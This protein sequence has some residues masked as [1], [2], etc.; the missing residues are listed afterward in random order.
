MVLPDG[1]RGNVVE[2]RVHGVS[3]TPPEELLDRQLVR[4][5]AGDA[6]AGFYRPRLREEWRDRPGNEPETD[7]EPYSTGSEQFP[8]PLLEGYSWGGLTSGSPSRALWLVLLPFTLINVAPRMR[9]V[10]GDT[11]D[12]SR[13][14]AWWVW[15]LARVMA[16]SL[17]ATIALGAT[18][19]GLTILAWQCSD[20]CENLPWPLSSMFVD[21]S[22]GW[23]VIWGAAIPFTLL[24]LL[25]LLS[26]RKSVQYDLIR[27]IGMSVPV[28]D[29]AETGTTAEPRLADPSFW[30]GRYPVSRLRHL[31]LQAG[32]AVVGFALVISS[33]S[34]G[35]RTAGILLAG[36]IGALVLVGLGGDGLLRRS[37]IPGSDTVEPSMMARFRNT[38]WIL[39]IWVPV[40]VLV[41]VGFALP[42]AADGTMAGYDP[43]V[44]AWFAGQSVLTLVMLVLIAVMASR[45]KARVPRRAAAGLGTVVLTILALYLGAA[46]TSGFVI[47]SAAWITSSTP[48]IGI[49]DV[50]DLL[51]PDSPIMVPGAL[52][53]AGIG[54]FAVAAVVLVVIVVTVVY[55]AWMWARG[56]TR[57][58]RRHADEAA[59]AAKSGD[60]AQFG[61]HRPG[62]I[63]RRKKSIS[64]SIWLARRVDLLPGF[65]AVLVISIGVIGAVVTVVIG[66]RVIVIGDG[67]DGF[68]EIRLWAFL[69]GGT[70]NPV[71]IG[72]W[73]IVG[74]LIALV[75]LG[76]LAFRVPKTRKSV[77]ILWDI[78]SFWPRDVH[79]LA[80]PC[81]AE[82]AVPELA[83]RLGA[84]VAMVAGDGRSGPGIDS[85]RQVPVGDPPAD[86][87]TPP[88]DPDTP[89]ADPDM[90]PGLV[91]LAAHS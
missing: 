45:E 32:V 64:R 91:V 63:G 80:P 89:P 70:L 52:Q 24:A 19:V 26:W 35:L 10:P 90:A 34:A 30:Y 77:G 12:D 5:V 82:R 62:T 39:L 73:L 38:G 11:P 54:T 55:A 23:R 18:G 9:P 61:R 42:H 29:P 72:V 7:S 33:P 81:Y 43:L 66:Y 49:G 28:T 41:A 37:D 22:A 65:L 78:G 87:V 46:L 14:T 47:L 71:A 69:G 86:P 53:Y 67:I 31:H 44:T 15:F 76:A 4:Q 40:L 51:A 25:A 74:L 75:V 79:P 6:T 8:P 59:D 16:V 48:W 84:H 3:G 58:D 88:A 56:G 13:R 83:M 1:S 2:L 57:A 60:P 50:E 17:T 68:G 21:A 36:L 27:P 20:S 85:V